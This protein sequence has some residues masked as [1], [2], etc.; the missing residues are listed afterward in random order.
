MALA[1]LRREAERLRATIRTATRRDRQALEHFRR[2]PA[3]LMT[4]AGLAPDDWQAGLL[5]RRAARTLLLCSRQAGKSTAAA[6]LSLGAALMEPRALVL[7]LSP[8]LR[9]SGEL[10]RKLL[11]L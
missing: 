1:T 8:S 6:A 9:Q 4:A 11:D 2:D 10:F 5:R 3:R 7:L